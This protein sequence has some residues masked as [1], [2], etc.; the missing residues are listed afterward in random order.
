MVYPEGTYDA[1]TSDCKFED[2]LLR[3]PGVVDYEG[4]DD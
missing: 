4:M 3:I 2:I 1:D